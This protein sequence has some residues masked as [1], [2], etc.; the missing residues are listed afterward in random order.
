VLDI[1]GQ[2][3]TKIGK[4]IHHFE[5]TAIIFC[6]SLSCYDQVLFEDDTTVSVKSFTKVFHALF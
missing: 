6:A 4:W 1:D 2:C 5:V 3:T